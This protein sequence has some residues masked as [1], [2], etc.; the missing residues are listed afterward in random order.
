M[1]TGLFKVQCCTY[2]EVVNIL[3]LINPSEIIICEESFKNF[4]KLEDEFIFSCQPDLTFDLNKAE[5]ALKELYEID[6]LTLLG[7]EKKEIISATGG[8]LNYLKSTQIDFMPRL[9]K[10]EIVNKE[11]FMTIDFS[12]RKSLELIFSQKNEKKGSLLHCIDKTIT[13]GGS[14]FFPKGYPLL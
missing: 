10:L 2:K 1:S 14:D 8:L 4:K 9:E 12:A 6:D 5:I 13:S 11:D 7:I 3:H